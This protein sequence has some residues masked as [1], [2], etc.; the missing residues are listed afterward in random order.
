MIYRIYISGPITDNPNYYEDFERAEKTLTIWNSGYELG[1]GI[2][3]EFINPARVS[4][5]MPAS[6]EYNDYM[7]VDML[8]L[9]KC[10]AIYMIRG[11]EKSRGGTC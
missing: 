4:D 9:T 11:Y 6:F 2:E 3:I 8:L 5:S 10:D 7:D 1:D